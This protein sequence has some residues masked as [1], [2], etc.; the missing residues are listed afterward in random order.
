MKNNDLIKEKINQIDKISK[1]K[2]S[3]NDSINKNKEYKTLLK[4]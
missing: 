4:N 3:L 2:N 1:V